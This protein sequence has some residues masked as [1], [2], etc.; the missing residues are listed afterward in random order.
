MRWFIYFLVE[1]L[2]LLIAGMKVNSWLLRYNK[3]TKMVKFNSTQLIN[4][5]L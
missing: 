3:Y 1:A 5:G 2:M 4:K